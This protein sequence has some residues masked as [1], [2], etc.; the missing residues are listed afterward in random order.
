MNRCSVTVNHFWGVVLTL[1]GLKAHL[2]VSQG[3]FSCQV[4]GRVTAHDYL[5]VTETWLLNSFLLKACGFY[6][7]ST[8]ANA[9]IN[10]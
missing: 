8:K 3:A 7:V 6:Q 10:I 2:H 9:V 4:N 5:L 1:Y